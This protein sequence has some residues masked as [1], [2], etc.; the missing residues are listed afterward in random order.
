MILRS[1]AITITIYMFNNRTQTV[2]ITENSA[3]GYVKLISELFTSDLVL[4]VKQ[5]DCFRQAICQLFICSSCFRHVDSLICENAS[6]V[7]TVDDTLCQ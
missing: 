5:N 1:Q 3:I 7:I 2:Q 6:S 4:L